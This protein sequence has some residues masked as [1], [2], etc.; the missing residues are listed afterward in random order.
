MNFVQSS[1]LRYASMVVML[2]VSCSGLG[3]Q[4][5]AAKS[6]DC[7][8]DQRNIATKCFN[9]YFRILDDFGLQ[10]SLGRL[11]LLQFESLFV[12]GAMVCNDLKVGGEEV[13]LQ[14]YMAEWLNIKNNNIVIHADIDYN[15][16]TSHF[17]DP[18]YRVELPKEHAVDGCDCEYQLLYLKTIWGGLDENDRQQSLNKPRRVYL[19][20]FIETNVERK[21]G[22]IKAIKEV[23]SSALTKG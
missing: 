22:F 19:R 20:F 15:L 7:G 17:D 21:V 3:A 9:E 2:M 12:P 11:D 6:N 8:P 16:H 5:Y 4:T 23:K 18:R 1:K 13:N 10:D 14:E